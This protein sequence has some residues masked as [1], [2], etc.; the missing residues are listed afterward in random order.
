VDGSEHDSKTLQFLHQLLA[1]KSDFQVTILHVGE[2]RM[3]ATMGLEME[4]MPVFLSAT[5]IEAQQQR[6]HDAAQ[7][8]LASAQAEAQRLGLTA[9]GMVRWGDPVTVIL[10][11]VEAGTFDLIAM[12]RHGVGR[13]AGIF[14]GSVSDP[15]A[16]RSQVPVLFVQ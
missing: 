11:T 15:I 6:Q 1:E 4:G 12:G 7:S 2:P 16:H 5:E 8:T 10:Q 14:L 3:L 13:I 9:T